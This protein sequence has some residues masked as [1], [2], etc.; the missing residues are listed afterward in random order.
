LP[1]LFTAVIPRICLRVSTDGSFD[2]EFRQQEP[3]ESFC[4]YIAVLRI[5]VVTSP[6]IKPLKD[7]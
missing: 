7:P 1:V 6:F 2:A 5:R 3:R 4:S